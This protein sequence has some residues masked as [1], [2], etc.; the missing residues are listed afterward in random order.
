[1][2]ALKA[3]LIAGAPYIALGALIIALIALIVAALAYRRL[4]QLRLESGASLEETMRELVKHSGDMRKFRE[5]LE[6]YL[7]HAEVRI[8]TSVRGVGVVRFN[9]FIGDGSGG[10][11]SFATALVNE[12]GD[13]VVFSAIHS[14]AG[15]ASVYAKPLSKGVSTFELTDEERGAIAKAMEGVKRAAGKQ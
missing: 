14:R 1:M 5:Q 3:Q 10:N 4:S 9:P 13:G 6:E 15:S 12:R 7:K 11:Q 8:H 2:L